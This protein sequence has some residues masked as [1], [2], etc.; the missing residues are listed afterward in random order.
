V[1][2]YEAGAFASTA[3]T[4][5]Y[6]GFW[7]RFGGYL[8]DGLLYGLLYLPFLSA[9]IALMAVGFD[10]CVTID[11]ELVCNGRENEGSIA[12]GVALMVVGAIVVFVVYLRGLARSG[13][14]WG[15]RIVGIKVVRT[16][17]GSAPGWGKAIGRTLFANWI[18]ASIF[19]LGYLW[20][21]WDGQKQ[22]WHDKVAG[23][24]VVRR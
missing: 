1:P 8:L 5:E 4:P 12:G 7:I 22:T 11:D 19:Y 14:T 13:M 10:D 3:P 21:L 18:S 15:R 17:D 16:D 24:Y 23:T 2:P 6:A 9:G 20:M